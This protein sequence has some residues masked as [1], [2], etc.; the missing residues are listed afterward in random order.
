MPHI[1]RGERQGT[2]AQVAYLEMVDRTTTP[3]R[4]AQLQQA[5]FEYCKLDT[6]AMV[7]LVHFFSHSRPTCSP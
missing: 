4:Q 2:E 5:L 3:E 7:K 6:L 1:F